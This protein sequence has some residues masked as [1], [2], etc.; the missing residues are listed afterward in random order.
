MRAETENLLQFYARQKISKKGKYWHM[1]YNFGGVTLFYQNIINCLETISI[2]EGEGPILGH[3]LSI[4]VYDC[5][6]Y[7]DNIQ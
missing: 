1:E 7:I 2:F 3:A 6:Q 5:I 4:F